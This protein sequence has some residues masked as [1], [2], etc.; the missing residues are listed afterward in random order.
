M[1]DI[2]KGTRD[3]ETDVGIINEVTGYELVH[4]RSTV[5]EK[6]C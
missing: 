4:K 3:S 2:K 5:L 1:Y 6:L